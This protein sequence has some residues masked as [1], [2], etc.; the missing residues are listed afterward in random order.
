MS[1]IPRIACFVGGTLFGSVGIKLLTSKDAKK[2]YVH[3]TTAGL[4]VRDCVMTTVDTVQENANDILAAA[5]DINNER[6]AQE[7]AEREA[8]DIANAAD[9]A[10]AEAEDGKDA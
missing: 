1:I 8:A 3:A 2:A 5:Q 10:D 6:A 7:E 9:D 4:R